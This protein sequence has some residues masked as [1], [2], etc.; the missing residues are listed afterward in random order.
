MPRPP[1]A[2]TESRRSSRAGSTRSRGRTAPRHSGRS[3]SPPA[4]ARATR[5][6][7]TPSPAASD[8]PPP[9]VTSYDACEVTAAAVGRKGGGSDV[10][11]EGAQLVAAVIGDLVGTPRRHP[12]PVDADVVDQRAEGRV[13]LVL[14]DVGQRAR[15]GGQRHVERD[16]VVVVHLR[17]VDQAKVDDV[18]AELRV[19]D[20]LHGLDD[21]LLGRLRPGPVG[22]RRRLEDLLRGSVAHDASLSLAATAC[23]VASFH[24]IHPSSAHLTR[25]GYL[26][27]PANAMPSSSTS[28]SGSS[29]P[30]LCISSRNA[31]DLLIAASIG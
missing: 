16:R 15:R 9:S 28:S 8:R 10:E 26:D 23:A 2:T 7:A 12:D 18:D 13:G 31:S 6:T 3:G 4:T 22:S 11:A 19:D 24:A 21:V 17:A 14:D 27:T 1:S 25:A 30:R 5:A 29:S 20:V